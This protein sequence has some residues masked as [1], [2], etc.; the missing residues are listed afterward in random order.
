MKSNLAF[1]HAFDIFYLFLELEEQEIGIFTDT[2][3]RL[4]MA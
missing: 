4:K 1:W 3:T 2:V